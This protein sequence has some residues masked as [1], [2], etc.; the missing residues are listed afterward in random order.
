ML[1]KSVVAGLGEIGNPILQLISKAGPTIGY[2]IND[3]LVD[4]TKYKKYANLKT[5][6]LHM[7][8]PFTDNFT[9]NVKTLYN[10]YKPQIIVIH[11]TISPY[12]TKNLQQIL[13]VPIIY[14]ATRGVHKRMLY[15]L[16]L[17]N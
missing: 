9:K 5:M 2:D 13:P 1:Y 3:S 4:K 7:C 14:S 17:E 6:F 10:K 11:S 16:F 15:D 8:I 12:T